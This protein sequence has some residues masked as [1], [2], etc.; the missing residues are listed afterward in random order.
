MPPVLLE[1]CAHVAGYE[2]TSARRAR[3]EFQEYASVI[4]FPGRELRE[5]TTTR[6]G[7]LKKQQAALLGRRR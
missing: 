5:Y 4:Q 3:G 7:H 1:L 6:F 2:I